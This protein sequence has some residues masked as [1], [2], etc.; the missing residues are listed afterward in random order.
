MGARDRI[1]IINI[2]FCFTLL[3]KQKHNFRLG[4]NY[5]HISVKSDSLNK[6]REMSAAYKTLVANLSSLFESR[7]TVAAVCI[8]YLYLT[9]L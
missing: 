9:Y 6:K 3:T 2:P 8:I 5:Y 1:C 7:A 4:I